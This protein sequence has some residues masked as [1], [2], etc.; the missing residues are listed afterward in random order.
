MLFLIIFD[1]S[2][3]RLYSSKEK[4]L[5]A[6][7]EVE[8]LVLIISKFCGNRRNKETISENI[9]KI[10][11]KTTTTTQVNN[12]MRSIREEELRLES[13][14]L[15]TPCYQDAV[16]LREVIQDLLRLEKERMELVAAYQMAQIRLYTLHLGASSHCST[17]EVNGSP[18]QVETARRQHYEEISNLRTKIQAIDE[19]VQEQTGELRYGFL[20]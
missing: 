15:G 1:R 8:N 2:S 7:D 17:P 18:A 3:Y 9:K 14:L 5:L 4:E 13:F 16:D 20:L 11:T 19:Q 6:A 10:E 12:L